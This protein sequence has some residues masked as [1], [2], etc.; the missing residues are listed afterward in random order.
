MKK[1]K[2]YQVYIAG[3]KITDIQLNL[4]IIIVTVIACLIILV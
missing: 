4:E 2:Y 3:H 1:N